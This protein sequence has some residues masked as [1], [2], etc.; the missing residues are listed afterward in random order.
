MTEIT[1]IKEIKDSMEEKDQILRKKEIR[2][3]KA[4]QAIKDIKA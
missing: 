3:P 4:L 2:V 1:V